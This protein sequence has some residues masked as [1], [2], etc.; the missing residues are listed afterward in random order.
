MKSNIF[1]L[2]L[3]FIVSG[4]CLFLIFR[5][6]DLQEVKRQLF[7]I[8]YAWLLTGACIGIVKNWLTGLRSCDLIPRTNK[9]SSSDSFNFYS[10]GIMANMIL[11]LRAG[12]IIRAKFIAN[13]LKI[14]NT[15][16]LGIIASEHILDFLMLCGL[17]VY[18]LTFYSYHWPSQVI[19]TV[20]SLFI[21]AIFLFCMIF[22]FNSNAQTINLLKNYAAQLLPKP[23]A[24]L[25]N[26]IANFYSGFF[27]LTSAAS[28]SKVINYTV[29]IWLAQALWIYALLCSLGMTE[30]YSF[31]FQAIFVMLVMMG[32]GIMIPFAPAYIGTFHLMIVLGLTQL[33]VQK[34][35]ALSYAIVAHAHAAVV[36]VLLGLFSL[37]KINMTTPFDPLKQPHITQESP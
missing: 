28:I 19:P 4:I 12:D 24:F 8:H 26:M 2:P 37:L 7:H 20:I 36:A 32:I 6:V 11:P 17:L 14:P 5:K 15:R 3:Y 1:K 10:I 9:L 21:F 33:G 30:M 31:G 35:T 23:L 18:C 22:I 29:I 27:Q 34:S 13:K 16:A 25:P